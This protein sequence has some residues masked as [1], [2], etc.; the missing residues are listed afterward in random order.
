MNFRL[1]EYVCE[2]SCSTAYIRQIGRRPLSA[3]HLVEATPFTEQ[4]AAVGVITDSRRVFNR[5]QPYVRH[6]EYHAR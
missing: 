2:S 1:F 3:L 6:G 4:N 5:S